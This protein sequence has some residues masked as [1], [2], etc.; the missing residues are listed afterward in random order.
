MV[1]ARKHGGRGDTAEALALYRRPGVPYP[2]FV[3]GPPLHP[4]GAEDFMSQQEMTSP[5]QDTN[6]TA[7]PIS[8]TTTAALKVLEF[9]EKSEQPE[10]VGLR[11]YVQG[12][13]SSYDYGFKFDHRQE[14][15]VVVPQEG[16]DLYVDGFSFH[17]LRGATVDYVDKVSGGGF[18]VDNPNEPDLSSNPLFKRV[19]EFID[20]HINPGVA[21]HG[22]S[23]SLL[24]VN[25][26]VV[27]VELGGGCQGCG[28]VDVTLKHGIE[29][30]LK[31]NFPE[32]ESVYDTTDHASG[33]NPYFSQG[34]GGA[35]NH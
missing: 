3:A 5:L 23:V 29:R 34:K 21:T 31:E 20:H 19:K 11:L 14:N 17:L 25:E 27:Y 30:M 22:G 12:G 6:V 13:R 24:E 18:S 2:F 1:D 8:F 15:D 32:I 9:A 35:F 33:D 10:D 7:K 16:F 26:G 4:A 28:M